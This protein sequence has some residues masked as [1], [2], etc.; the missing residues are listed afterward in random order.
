LL[1]PV[2]LGLRR[3]DRVVAGMVLHVFHRRA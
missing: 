1:A 3:P 2:S